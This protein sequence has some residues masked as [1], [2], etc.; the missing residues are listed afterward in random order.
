[1]TL[2]WKAPLAFSAVLAALF[3]KRV[4]MPPRTFRKLARVAFSDDPVRTVELC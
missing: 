2:V 4:G 3:S 1:M